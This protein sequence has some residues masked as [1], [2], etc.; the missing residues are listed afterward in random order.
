MAEHDS[1]LEALDAVRRDRGLLERLAARIPGYG[2]L[3]ERD[4][5]REVDQRQR[6]HLA[7]RVHDA[8]SLLRGAARD[9]TDAGDLAALRPLDRAERRLDRL[10]ESMRFA[11]YGASGLFGVQ[12]IREAELEALYRF[13]LDLLDEVDALHAATEQVSTAGDARVALARVEQLAEAL[14]TRWAGRRAVIDTIVR[15]STDR[16]STES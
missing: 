1:D 9:A 3:M 2:G 6:E 8:K 13:D 4:L 16:T 10:G 7:R 15:T 11:D 14:T 5:R 12:K